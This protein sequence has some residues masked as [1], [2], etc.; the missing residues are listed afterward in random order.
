MSIWLITT[1]IPVHRAQCASWQ[2]KNYIKEGFD[3]F[4]PYVMSEEKHEH[5]KQLAVGVKYNN[6]HTKW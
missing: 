3:L 1:L 2:F 6:H 5:K 4:L